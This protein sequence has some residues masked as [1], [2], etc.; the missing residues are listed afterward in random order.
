MTDK[1]F[2]AGGPENISWAEG[3]KSFFGREMRKV[4][5]GRRTDKFFRA[6][7]QEMIMKIHHL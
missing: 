5:P 6:G 7:G 4:F 2:R 3:G 1:F